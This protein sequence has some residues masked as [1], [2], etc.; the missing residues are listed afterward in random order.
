MYQGMERFK[1]FEGIRKNTFPDQWHKSVATPFPSI[2]N[3][4][5]KMLSHNPKDRPS[6][7]SVANE[8]EALL[9]EYTVLSLDRATTRQEGSLFLRVEAVDKE[10]ILAR[11][12]KL[13]KDTAPTVTILQYSLRGQD[14]K[15]IMEFAL[16]LALP[17][18]P[19]GEA[20]LEDE[21]IP[22]TTTTRST[23]T[24]DDA[25]G[26][27]RLSLENIL[28]ALNNCEEVKL[29]RQI[30]SDKY[31]AAVPS[32]GTLVPDPILSNIS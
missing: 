28:T 22:T 29:V 17:L 19:P 18:P 3:L 30:N 11:T 16:L 4:V 24:M 31:S 26:L 9:S 23:I 2:H 5:C 14:S 6:S 21:G 10:G 12:I 27:R 15:A 25:M 32:D 7:A 1:A 8:I 20:A 13:I